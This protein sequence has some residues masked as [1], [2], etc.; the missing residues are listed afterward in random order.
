MKTIQNVNYSL[1]RLDSEADARKPILDYLELIAKGST[2]ELNVLELGSGN[3]RNLE[4][5]K[6]YNHKVTAV[7]GLIDAVEVCK[8]KGIDSFLADL[9]QGLEI[10]SD[11][12]GFDLILILDVLE[13]LVDPLN[14]LKEC[15]KLVSKDGMVIIN[16]PN[17]FTLQGRLRIL[18]GS[19]IDSER[20]FPEACEWMYPHLRFFTHKGAMLMVE[21]A[22]FCVYEDNSKL[23]RRTPGFLNKIVSLDFMWKRLPVDLSCGGFLLVIK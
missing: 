8:E 3:G 4:I 7:D 23:L 1:D 9:D 19:G 21:K 2:K 14:L 20:F 16:L 10:E 17:H 6:K 18:L 15:K 12:K 13:H 11:E 5:F 22:G